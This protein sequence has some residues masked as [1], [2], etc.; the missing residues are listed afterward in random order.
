VYD[1]NNHTYYSYTSKFDG[2]WQLVYQE[3]VATRSQAM[4]RERQLKSGAGR[5]FIKSYIPE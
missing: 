3:L 4:R 5:E 1:H 2:E